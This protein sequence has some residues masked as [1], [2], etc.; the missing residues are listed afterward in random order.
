[1][2]IRDI[3]I[4]ICPILTLSECERKD[5]KNSICKN[6]YEIIIWKLYLFLFRWH[7][8]NECFIWKCYYRNISQIRLIS[9]FLFQNKGCLFIFQI[10]QGMENL[11]DKA[12]P[13]FNYIW[14]PFGI[15]SLI[16]INVYEYK[17]SI[18][19][20]YYNFMIIDMYRSYICM[21]KNNY[22]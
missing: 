19:I 21:T 18:A 13:P 14:P 7:F 16:M 20:F 10:A 9:Y 15:H 6:S 3:L 11:W 2:R 4:F 1:M 17:Y 22:F 12:C 8:W 5:Q